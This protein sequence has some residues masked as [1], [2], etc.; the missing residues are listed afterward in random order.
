[1]ALFGFFLFTA[2]P[3][4]PS[5]RLIRSLRLILG[6]GLFL[7]GLAGALE[8]AMHNILKGVFNSPPPQARERT[9][10]Q[11]E[12]VDGIPL[13]AGSI[14]RM[15]GG[16]LVG[17]QL[18]RP[19]TIDGLSVT[20]DLGFTRVDTNGRAHDAR[21]SLATLAADQEIPS[22]PGVWCSGGQRI[23]MKVAPRSLSN[24]VLA[25]ALTLDGVQ[26]PA[27]AWLMLRDSDWRANLS[28]G[29]PPVM[30]EGL[31]VPAGWG[32]E[33]QRHPAARL[34]KLVAPYLPPPEI[35]PWLEIHGVPLTQ[36]IN[37]NTDGTVQGIAWQDAI[38][39]GKD[40]KKGDFVKFPR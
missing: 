5:S 29:S 32:I 34:S 15:A 10:A 7:L 8:P 39:E 16:V 25:R 31:R 1:M 37:F 2:S 38:V 14:V 13:P 11:D 6:G 28:Q 21:L 20:G 17:A 27:S 40:Y 19:Q 30:V 3:N 18:Q 23:E 4:P 24:C 12:I 9:V 26:I 35:Q 33:V 22:S 36:E